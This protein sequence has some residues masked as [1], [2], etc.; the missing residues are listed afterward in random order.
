MDEAR[1]RR[2][3]AILFALAWP[4]PTYALVGSVLI[5]VNE[6]VLG[7]HVFDASTYAAAAA[8]A[9]MLAA[10]AGSEHGEPRVVQRRRRRHGLELSPQTAPTRAAPS[11]RVQA[12]RGR[13]ES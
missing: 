9:S 3:S 11:A 7:A 4:V 5:T 10:A 8:L 1:R 6:R 13:M 2:W 12:E